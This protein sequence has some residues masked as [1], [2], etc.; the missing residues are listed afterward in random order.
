MTDYI[1][2]DIHGNYDGFKDLLSLVNF[3]TNQDSLIILC[4]I[5]D[6]GRKTKQCIDLGLSIPNMQFVQ[7]NHDCVDKNTEIL[8]R[9]GWRKY[10]KIIP[11]Y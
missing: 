9:N 11:S 5:V 8:T 2:A 7:G 3:D 1:I 4:D 10:N 6:G